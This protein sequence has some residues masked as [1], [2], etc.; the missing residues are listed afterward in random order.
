MWLYHIRKKG[1]FYKEGQYKKN[2]SNKKGLSPAHIL[3][4][5]TYTKTPDPWF[6][7]LATTHKIKNA[8]SHIKKTPRTIF[9]HLASN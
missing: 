4:Q 6:S 8:L 2:K 3:F 9:G 1:E 7:K 5:K